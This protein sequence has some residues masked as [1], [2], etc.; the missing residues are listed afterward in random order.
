MSTQSIPDCPSTRPAAELD[1]ETLVQVALEVYAR[2]GMYGTKVL[3]D[4]AME[5]RSELLKRLRA[6]PEAEG[7]RPIE[8]APRDGT[9]ICAWSEKEPSIV[10]LVR[11]GR[12]LG[13]PHWRWVTT[14]KSTAI[15][16]LP[17]H[18]MPLPAF[19]AA[20]PAQ[21]GAAT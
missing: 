8:S 16:N 12:H 2:A 14:T 13:G 7:W 10:R 20:A 17:S 3:H 1:A 11:W 15:T 19:P 5:C 9:C 21:E 4:R 18:W 6:L